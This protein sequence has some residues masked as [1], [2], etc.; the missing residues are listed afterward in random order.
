[1]RHFPK[2]V[3]IRSWQELVREEEARSLN[4]AGQEWIFR[5]QIS[6]QSLVPTLERLLSTFRVNDDRKRLIEKL[7]I[8]DF[9][10]SCH[11]YEPELAPPGNEVTE[12]LSLMRHFGAPTRLLDFTQSLFIASY[13]ALDSYFSS[14]DD[15][16]FPVVW[17]VDRTWLWN[18]LD[19]QIF[20][21]VKDEPSRER[22]RDAW[23]TSGD[24]S[25]FRYLFMNDGKNTDSEMKTMLQLLPTDDFVAVLGAYRR[26]VRLL[27]QQGTFVASSTITRPFEAVLEAMPDFLGH[28][29]RIEF[30]PATANQIMARLYRMGLTRSLLF[31]GLEGFSMSL[32]TKIPTYLEIFNLRSDDEKWII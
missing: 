21:R 7:L 18:Y 22:I 9:T 19:I 24:D 30:E 10:R 28:V 17:A 14:E 26:N 15:S 2:A 32:S 31:P 25:V 23:R 4:V 3:R 11:V 5:G 20:G 6:G 1:M 16:R 29:A 8:E 12:W 13:F 27:Q